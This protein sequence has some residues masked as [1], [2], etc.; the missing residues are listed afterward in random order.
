MRRESPA[1]NGASFRSG[2][3][4]KV[5]SGL[6]TGFYRRGIRGKL[7]ALLSRVLYFPKRPLSPKGWR[8][9]L[10]GSLVAAGISFLV[11]LVIITGVEASVGKNLSC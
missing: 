3:V 1:S 6:Q 9:V 8:S 7:R 5:P 4:A 10:V 11:G 2:R